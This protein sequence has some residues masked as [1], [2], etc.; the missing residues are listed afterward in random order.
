MSTVEEYDELAAAIRRYHASLYELERAGVDMAPVRRV[1]ELERE[2]A[3]LRAQLAQEAPV[4]R[5]RVVK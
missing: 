1:M 3:E 5:L 2:N 4:R